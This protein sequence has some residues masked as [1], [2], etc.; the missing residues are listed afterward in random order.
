MKISAFLLTL[1]TCALAL[2]PG[3]RGKGGGYYWRDFH[4]YFALAA[5][6]LD[7]HGQP[8][9]AISDAFYTEGGHT[10]SVALL[11]GGSAP[12]LKARL[13]QAYTVADLTYG[14]LDG[15]GLQD[16][17]ILLSDVGQPNLVKICLQDPAH[18]GQFLAPRTISLPAGDDWIK[19]ADL[20]G[21]GCLDIVTDTGQPVVLFQDPA[22]R[23][24]FLAP[25]DLGI[26]RGYVVCCDL[27][28]DGRTDVAVTAMD[29]TLRLY[30]QTPTPGVLS[31]GPVYALGGPPVDFCMG[32]LDG[33]GRP[34]L[35]VAVQT[36]ASPVSGFLVAYVHDAGAAASFHTVAT[37]LTFSGGGIGYG[38]GMVCA[39]FDGDG[40]ADIAYTQYGT[41]LVTT[42][43]QL[44]GPTVAFGTRTDRSGF[45][46]PSV[47]RAFDLDGDGRKDL[48]VAADSVFFLR[49]DPA[50]PGSFLA[51]VRLL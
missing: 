31:A 18:P 34:D 20:N 35:V 25:A 36:H 8:Q 7:G 44:P 49:Q 5:V 45:T 48:L 6:D 10:N 15:D 51:P 21:D 27:D 29:G 43:L 50:H 13:G 24:T 19:L 30:L 26:P 47:L 23:G 4:V 28:G 2:L 38:Y 42:C 22:H 39:D 11:S 37:G 32:D 40:K 33:D 1:A 41:G 9:V 46:L 14:D 16:L 12:T 17:V 3:C